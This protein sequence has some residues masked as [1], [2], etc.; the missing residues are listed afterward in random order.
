MDWVLGSAG[1]LP[2]GP[3]RAS[4]LSSKLTVSLVGVNDVGIALES[5]HKEARIADMVE[6]RNIQEKCIV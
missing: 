1:R 5:M 3:D 6:S 4:A 2:S